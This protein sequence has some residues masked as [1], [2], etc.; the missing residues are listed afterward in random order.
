MRGENG[1]QSQIKMI[2]GE[3]LTCCFGFEDWGRGPQAK[4][5][6][7]PLEDGTGQ[8]IHSPLINFRKEY[9][10]ANTSILALWD[11][12]QNSELQTFKINIYCFQPLSLWWF[13][14]AYIEIYVGDNL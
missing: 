9:T 14:T 1:S 7:W 5:C 12:S 6:Q 3:N 8:V 2:Q 4:E 10:S 13:V 11:P